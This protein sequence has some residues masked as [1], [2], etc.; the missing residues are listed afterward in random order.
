M[1]AD[2][3]YDCWYV[4]ATSDEIQGERSD[5]RNTQ[6][7]GRD[8]GSGLLSRRLLGRHVV[9]YRRASGDVVALADR[10]AHRPHPLSTGYRDG[11][12][13]VCGYHGFGYDPDG[14]LV[15]V[16]SQE[17][18]PAGVRVHA[19][20]VYEEPPF[21]WVWTGDPGT[22]ARRPP[23]RAP[24]PV[25]AGAA[26]S[27]E[28]LDIRANYL[29]LHEH[30][31]DLTNVFHMYPEAAPPDL[32]ALPPLD[33]VAVSERSV[34]YTR[35]TAESRPAAWEIATAGLS[36]RERTRRVEEGA[37]VSPALHVQRY[38]MDPEGEPRTLLRI[39]AF[40]PERPGETRVYLRMVRDFNTGDAAVTERLRAM[41]HEMAVRD[42]AALELVQ[43]RMD[44][45]RRDG[46]GVLDRLRRDVNVTADRAALRARRIVARM[47][48][49]E[50][51]V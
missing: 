38:V 29:L 40:T 12:R 33:E 39:Q 22:A 10:C 41:F 27:L 20:P 26:E 44:E 36:P 50:A 32:V 13:I 8:P 5:G 30:Y 21:V 11:D 43:V 37:F 23:P 7:D 15:D 14:R 42:A 4:A 6:G 1:R 16:P 47:V 2:Y 24:W 25:P 19:Y 35:T 3:P 51:R 9:L 18:V 31:L 48:A 45:E 46:P 34:T 17:R 28:V 49:D